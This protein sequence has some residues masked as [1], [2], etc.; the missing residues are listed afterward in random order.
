MYS[1]SIL[2]HQLPM[3]VEQWEPIATPRAELLNGYE[4]D[5]RCQSTTV[6]H[7]NVCS[8]I[9]MA[10]R[11]SLRNR[12]LKCT[13]STER[14][15]VRIN[16]NIAHIPDAWIEC[17]RD[18]GLPD[19]HIAPCTVVEVLSDSTRPYDNTTKLS[20]YMQLVGFITDYLIVDPANRSAVRHHKMANND[21]FTTQYSGDMSIDLQAGNHKVCIRMADVFEG[22]ID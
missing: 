6:T 8:N 5:L 1:M 21:V 18:A 11:A 4:Y 22:L 3:T 7:A 13:A 9:V 10:L 17:E 20:S 15:L 16:D 19:T 12:D 2:A 14:P